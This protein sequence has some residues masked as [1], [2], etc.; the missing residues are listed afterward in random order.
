MSGDPL[1]SVQHT[2]REHHVPGPTVPLCNGSATVQYIR[3]NYLSEQREQLKQGAPF[4]KIAKTKDVLLFN[5]GAHY[6][7]DAAKVV[8]EMELFAATLLT[9]PAHQ[10]V[11]WR[12]T[13]P[14]HP[15][16]NSTDS[17]PWSNMKVSAV[18]GAAALDAVPHH[19]GRI[20]EQNDLIVR[21]L[22]RVAPGVITYVDAFRLSI[23]RGD[24]HQGGGDCLHYCLP[25]PPDTWID[26]FAL[27]T[28]PRWHT[29]SLLASTAN[30]PKLWKSFAAPRERRP[31]KT[32]TEER[33]RNA[34]ERSVAPP[35]R[36]TVYP[37]SRN[38][39]DMR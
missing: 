37:H 21:T 22:S 2:S 33:T 24:R 1:E 27:K 25:G 18:F 17:T 39:D 31:L 3:N 23:T 13:V 38:E 14:G 7:S 12:T 29:A 16:C 4:W 11:F 8:L 10:K 32:P 28:D 30:P 26:V 6:E 9:H 36:T 34:A 20:S 15:G 35:H 19:W 5:R